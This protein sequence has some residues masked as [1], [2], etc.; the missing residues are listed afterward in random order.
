[1][2]SREN[3]EFQVQLEEMDF[4]DN[5]GCQDHQDRWAHRVRMVTRENLANLVKKV[6]KEEKETL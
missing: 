4:P 5:A 6:S 3:L 1:M 2:I